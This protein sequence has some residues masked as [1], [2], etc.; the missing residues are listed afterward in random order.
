MA[1]QSCE[2]NSRSPAAGSSL[3]IVFKLLLRMRKPYIEMSN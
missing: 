1:A 2:D 3:S